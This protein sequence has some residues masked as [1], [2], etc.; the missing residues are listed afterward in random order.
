MVRGCFRG[1][2]F[3]RIEPVCRLGASRSSLLGNFWGPLGALMGRFGR[4]L[5]GI[6]SRLMCFYVLI[7][8]ILSPLVQ[9]HAFISEIFAFLL[10]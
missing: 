5:G 2:V 3:G 4:L 1:P 7:S 10:L 8:K 9:S 6:F